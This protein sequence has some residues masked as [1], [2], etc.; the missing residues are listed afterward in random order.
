M[1]SNI[2]IYQVNSWFQQYCLFVLHGHKTQKATLVIL[3]VNAQQ[4]Y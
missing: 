1:Y 4:Q 2:L 3:F